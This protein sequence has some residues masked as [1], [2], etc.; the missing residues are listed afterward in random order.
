MPNWGMPVRLTSFG[1]KDIDRDPPLIL[2]LTSLVLFSLPGNEPTH[3]G[4]GK[5]FEQE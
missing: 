4:F 5:E 1:N 2:F 3:H